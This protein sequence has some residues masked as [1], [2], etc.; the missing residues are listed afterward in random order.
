MSSAGVDLLPA[1]TRTLPTHADVVVLGSG[2]TGLHAALPLA[3]A[4][5]HVV[6]LEAEGVGH[7]CSSRN[8]GQISTAIKPGLARLTRRHGRDAA[9]QL[10]RE[11]IDSVDWLDG[12]I[13]REAINCQYVRCGSFH[14]AHTPGQFRMMQQHL[15]QEPPELRTGAWLIEPDAM[16]AEIG[17]SR[18]FGGAVYPQDGSLQPA[19][20]HQ[21]LL[22]LTLTAGA[23]IHTQTRALSLHPSKQE[24]R[25][26]TSR[27]DITA[28]DVVV[29]TNGY[30][31]SATP[32]LQRRVIPV[33]SYMIATEPLSSEVMNSVLPTDRI[34]CDTRKVIYYYRPSP[35]RTRVVFGGRV[36]TG[37]VAPEVSAPRLLNALTELFPQ[38]EGVRVSHSW[39]GYV[40][41]TF[42][43]L[44][45]IG[46]EDHVHHALG[47][48]GSGIAMS[49]YFGARIGHQLAG[50]AHAA[51][52]LDRAPAIRPELPFRTR[53]FYSGKPWF[54]SA[55]IRYYR[56]RDRLAH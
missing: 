2:Y 48:C 32:E 11:G 18:Y 10:H 14:G 34:I 4:G 28:T 19:L 16:A 12:F 38:L 36:S 47:Y 29:A 44:A 35:D 22:H 49:S 56:W 20:Y 37:E 25:V 17:T 51:D 41:F 40:A 39:L 23:E 21:G 26:S 27:G 13:T 24:V 53:P 5:R 31:G 6:V 46:R 42:D 52:Y 54:L 30:T 45:H 3:R 1:S 50:T 8:G 7:G 15:H 55:A 9:L 33:G 43:D